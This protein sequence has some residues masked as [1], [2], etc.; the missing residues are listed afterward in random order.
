MQTPDTETP[1]TMRTHKYKKVTKNGDV[2]I[3]EYQYP[4]LKKDGKPGAKLNPLC[5]TQIS[6]KLKGLDQE[7]LAQ[8][9]QLISQ[10]V[11]GH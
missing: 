1:V 8:V 2:K 7:Q 6:H 9:H 5:K 3:Y 4:A 11:T 10:Y